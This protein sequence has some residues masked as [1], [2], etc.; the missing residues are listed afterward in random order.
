MVYHDAIEKQSSVNDQTDT[1]VDQ[2]IMFKV[3]RQGSSS[4]EDQNDTSDDLIG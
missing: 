4:S 1:V 3:N 2:D